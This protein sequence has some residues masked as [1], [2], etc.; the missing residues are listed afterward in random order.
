MGNNDY[1]ARRHPD[2]ASAGS[3]SVCGILAERV[4]RPRFVD[5]GLLEV[6]GHPGLLVHLAVLP[7]YLP[8]SLEM[9]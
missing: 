8:K 1:W 6:G 3:Q 5:L 2:R 9:E 4:V 7:M